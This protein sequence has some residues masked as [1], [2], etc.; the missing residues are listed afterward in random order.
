MNRKKE[1]REEIVAKYPF[2]DLSKTPTKHS[3][4]KNSFFLK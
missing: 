3:K 4:Q 1:L 2:F